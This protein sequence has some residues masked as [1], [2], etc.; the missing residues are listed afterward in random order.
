MGRKVNIEPEIITPSVPLQAP[1]EV[2]GIALVNSE[3]QY[4]RITWVGQ[5]GK[6]R[7]SMIRWPC[8]TWSA[9]VKIGYPCGPCEFQVL[10]KTTF[11]AAADALE[12][13]LVEWSPRALRLVTGEVSDDEE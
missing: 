11:C 10:G 13:V 12:E 4:D 9:Y 5:R 2:F 8:G 7:V 1:I 6:A 3:I